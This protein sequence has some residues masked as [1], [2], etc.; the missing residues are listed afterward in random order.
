MNN[1]Q[2]I[3][4][5]ET[6]LPRM[7]E[8]GHPE[9]VLLKYASDRNLAPAQLEKMTQI[10]NTAAT[11]TYL[12]KSED[13]GG[14]FHVIDTPPLLQEYTRYTPV[15]KEAS[16]GTTVSHDPMRFPRGMEKAASAVDELL[17][18]LQPE[19]PSEAKIRQLEE[20][21]KSA[22]VR[23]AEMLGE[24]IDSTD[25]TINQEASGILKIARADNDLTR[26]LIEGDLLYMA[27]PELGTWAIDRIWGEP[28]GLE[29]DKVASARDFS[30]D[31]RTNPGRLEVLGHLQRMLEKRA[32]LQVAVKYASTF[33]DEDAV[34]LLAAVQGVSPQQMKQTLGSGHSPSG[35][36]GG[37]GGTGGGSG[38]TGGGS[39]GSPSTTV[40]LPT[41]RKPED[42]LDPGKALDPVIKG[43]DNLGSKIPMTPQFFR[44]KM[45]DLM[46]GPSVNRS[47]MK[48]D[49]SRRETERS[50]T[51]AR[52]M[53]VDP[54]ISEADPDMVQELY[55]TLQDA[56]PEFVKDPAKLRMALREAVQYES[57]P[58][59][60][61]KEIA[62]TRKTIA[63]ARSREG[64]LSD[65]EY[66]I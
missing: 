34:A 26:E 38:G 50:L 14:S 58:L 3:E 13:R 4:V 8:E 54:I 21:H 60:T 59:H 20:W 2:A 37:T 24:F 40:T 1:Q 43:M 44:E 27:G 36:G 57:V 52:L 5:L 35:S 47:Q 32:E 12:E 30:E 53:Q 19:G 15:E 25:Y 46:G 7:K 41:L 23:E 10:Y 28:L 48:V 55:N 11:L 18:S 63:D 62:D 42:P 29:M 17:A 65:R 9:Q 16:T 33:T 56:S 66:G 6:L 31:L 22:C 51:L 45:K 49:D 64:E 39:G 61:L